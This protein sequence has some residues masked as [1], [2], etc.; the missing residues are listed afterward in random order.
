MNKHMKAKNEHMNKVCCVNL[1]TTKTNKQTNKNIIWLLESNRS[2]VT[3]NLSLDRPY[4]QN[5]IQFRSDSKYFIACCN[6]NSY[7][8]MFLRSHQLCH[9]K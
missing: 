7:M 8:E 5:S 3:D 1:K 2:Q 6:N 4:I 9:I